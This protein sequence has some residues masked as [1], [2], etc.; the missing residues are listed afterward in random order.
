MSGEL[1]KLKV[2]AYQEADY[3]DTPAE[4]YIFE[5]MFNPTNYVRKY[6]VEYQDRQGAGD[7]ASPQIY[8]NIKP[9]DYNFELTIDGTGATGVKV[10]VNDKVEHFLKVTGK[11]DGDIHRPRYLKVIWGS[12]LVK[13]VLKSAEVTYNLFKPDG[14]PLRA[15]IRFTVSE[16]VEDT[17]RVAE[18]GNNSP[19]LTHKRLVHEGDHLPLMTN[20]IYG[21]PDY[22]LQ[23]AAYNGLKNFRRLR[24]GRKLFFPP[25]KNKEA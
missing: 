12:L 20:R 1:T 21:T 4:D 9:Q 7:T 15:K 22:Y 17:L 2:E 23:V 6:E 11:N 10:D 24:A 3:S 14:T 18:A 5:V 8:G 19:D 16:N 25:V 13:C